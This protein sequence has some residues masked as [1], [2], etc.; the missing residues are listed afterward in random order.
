MGVIFGK[1]Q[2]GMACLFGSRASP[3]HEDHPRAYFVFAPSVM[4]IL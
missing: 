1:T 2:S 4:V 3:S